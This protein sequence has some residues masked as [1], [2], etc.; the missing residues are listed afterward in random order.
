MENFVN[1]VAE[2][3]V[4]GQESFAAQ[5]CA[6]VVDYVVGNFVVDIAAGSYVAVGVGSCGPYGPLHHN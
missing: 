6:A 5:M 3:V 2:A 1:F 4:A